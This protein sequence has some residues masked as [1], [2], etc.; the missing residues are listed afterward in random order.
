MHNEWLTRYF[1]V[2]RETCD[3]SSTKILSITFKF[4]G[5]LQDHRSVHKYRR[6]PQGKMSEIQT[7]R[8]TLIHLTLQNDFFPSVFRCPHGGHQAFGCPT[9]TS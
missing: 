5:Q 1:Y 2:E 4:H 7:P 8:I 3:R 6:A 9:W